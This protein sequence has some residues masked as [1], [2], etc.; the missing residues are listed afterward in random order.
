MT[1]LNHEVLAQFKSGNLSVFFTFI[2][3]DEARPYEVEVVLGLECH[4]TRYADREEAAAHFHEAVKA[5][6]K[7]I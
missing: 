2:P 5:G 4:C 3:M 7:S 1:A 6:L